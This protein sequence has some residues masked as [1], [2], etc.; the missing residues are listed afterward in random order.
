M[1][2]ETVLLAYKE[3][4]NKLKELKKN[5]G[6]VSNTLKSSLFSESI[7]QE[8]LNQT[9]STE[10]KLVCQTVDLNRG[11]KNTGEWLGAYLLAR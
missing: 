3:A 2:N 8:L 1:N 10:L 4:R 9:D 11:K 6:V 5:I 7:G